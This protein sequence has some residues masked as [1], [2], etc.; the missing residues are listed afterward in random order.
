M[1]FVDIQIY[2]PSLQRDFLL[3][4][5]GTPQ[6]IYNSTYSDPTYEYLYALVFHHR[7]R[8]CNSSEPYY[9]PVDELCYAECPNYYYEENQGDYCEECHY[10]CLTCTGQLSSNC[11]S[12]DN[13]TNRVLE[14]SACHCDIG[15]YDDN[16]AVC[17]VCDNLCL[18]CETTSGNCIS[19]NTT[20]N[21]ELSSNTCVCKSGYK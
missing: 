13:S 7:V 16:T 1:G 17:L 14:N 5:I 8:V 15:Y 20:A 12:C 10:S 9:Y 2:D 6:V 18:T 21:R 4:L 19:C 11:E 3:Q